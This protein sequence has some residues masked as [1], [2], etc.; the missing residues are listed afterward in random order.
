MNGSLSLGQRR[1]VEAIAPPAGS[2][3]Y[4]A[5]LYY[6]PA[7]RDTLHALEAIR[8]EITRIPSTCSDRGVAHTKLAWWY[9]EFEQ[10]ESGTPRHDFTKALSVVMS[11]C[12]QYA[13]S[14]QT[15]VASVDSSLVPGTFDD[16]ADVLDHLKGIHGEICVL[17][18]GMG[19]GD[20][21]FE[22]QIVELSCLTEL[23]Y[24]MRG[25]RLHRNAPTLC[26][27]QAALRRHG[28]TPDHIRSAVTS[29][30]L[31][32]LIADEMAW[33]QAALAERLSALPRRTRRTIQMVATLGMIQHR[34]LTL[35]LADGC[36]VLEE[37]IEL[38]P[39]SKLAIAWRNRWIPW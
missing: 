15:L 29:A 8:R 31:R 39:L 1:S 7:H 14:F 13:K 10:L 33:L 23:S 16:R 34:A 37:R 30:E 12:Q 20:E 6:P 27:P 11:D 32:Q 36:P 9:D 38:T 5:S 3:F 19:N 21:R 18:A 35:C 26:L 4:Y 25:L 24:E 22:D 2:D 17:M 28:L